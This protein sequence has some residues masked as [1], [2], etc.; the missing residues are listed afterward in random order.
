LVDD[1]TAL[2]RYVLATHPTF[3]ESMFALLKTNANVSV[4]RLLNRLPPS[5]SVLNGIL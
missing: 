3:Y 2:P 4:W 5:Q 1:E